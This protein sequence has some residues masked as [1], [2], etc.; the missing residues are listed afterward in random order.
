MQRCMK[1]VVPIEDGGA[2]P[3]RGRVWNASRLAGRKVPS[4]CNIWRVIS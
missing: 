4:V 2:A 3:G 1:L